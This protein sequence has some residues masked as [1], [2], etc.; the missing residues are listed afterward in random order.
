MPTYAIGQVVHIG[1]YY[2][3]DD[4]KDHPDCLLWTKTRD[5]TSLKRGMVMYFLNTINNFGREE[6]MCK[7]R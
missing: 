3:Y 7:D 4:N 1:K 2:V 5:T 6:V